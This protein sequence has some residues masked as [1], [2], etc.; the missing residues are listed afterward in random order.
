VFS[1]LQW[2]HQGIGFWFLFS[3]KPSVI[4]TPQGVPEKMSQTITGLLFSW[5]FLWK[6]PEELFFEWHGTLCSWV[7]L[8]INCLLL[9]SSVHQ[10]TWKKGRIY[11]IETSHKIILT[12]LPPLGGH[13][14]GRCLDWCVVDNSFIV[15]FDWSA[16]SCMLYNEITFS[17][18]APDFPED[19]LPKHKKVEKSINH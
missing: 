12:R 7:F 11:E 9:D 4:I 1:A 16:R 19:L 3:C 15:P 14:G 13:V 10:L 6:Q 8:W 2:A 17:P 18:F 5:S